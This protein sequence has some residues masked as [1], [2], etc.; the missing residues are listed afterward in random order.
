MDITLVSHASVV[1][2]AGGMKIW[3]DPWTVSKVFN[4]S[5]SL[6]GTPAYTPEM[7][8]SI[9]YLWIS[10]EHPDHF[11]VPTLKSLPNAFKQRVVLLFQQ[12][13]S[14]KVFQALRGF[15]FTQFMS[16]PHGR[17][18]ALDA[19]LE[20][21]C[22][23][24]SLGDSC[25]AIR[26]GG[27]VVLNINDAELSSPDCRRI[28]RDIGSVDVVLNQFSLAGYNGYRHPEQV[29]PAMAMEKL[30]RL[31]NNHRDL[32]AQVTV[33]FAS[34]VYFSSADNRFINRYGNTPRDVAAY[35]AAQGLRTR[36]LYLGETAAVQ[37]LVRSCAGDGEHALRQW[38]RLYD[39]IEDLDYTVDPPRGLGELQALADA[40]SRALRQYYPAL[41][42]R[43]VTPLTFYLRDVQH[44]VRLDVLRGTLEP[45][46][47]AAG[48][49]DILLDSQPLAAAL[50]FPSGFETLAVSGRFLV[51]HR[52]KN[53]QRP[54]NLT[55][56]WNNQ[57]FLR[58]RYLL[59]GAVLRYLAAR[60]R[61]GLLR[62]VLGKARVRARAMR[63][64]A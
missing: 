38:Q 17:I 4:N 53:W 39:G 16:L 20:V 40:F 8:S 22:Y 10:H 51:Q 9:R 55:I 37:D 62:Q 50:K 41:L 52:F 32:A 27:E 26:H 54:K 28:A 61:G 7:L 24:A 14:E 2:D 25:L 42:L 11:N 12:H 19:G 43:R 58:P 33:P 18:V 46:D 6:L 63:A 49:A 59:D 57:I 44:A 64:Q 31:R 56:L 13:H 3:S 47:T 60:T 36:F 29:L 23:Q 1:V 48:Q 45:S 15:G 35:M 21:Y 34:F 30:V 5:W